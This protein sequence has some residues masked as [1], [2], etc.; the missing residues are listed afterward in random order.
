M[1]LSSKHGHGFLRFVSS[2]FIFFPSFTLHP[3]IRCPLV[4]RLLLRS[5]ELTVLSVIIITVSHGPGFAQLG[6][7]AQMGL[8]LSGIYSL[9]LLSITAMFH[10]HL[11]SPKSSLGLNPTTG[12]ELLLWKRNLLT[13]TL[14]HHCRADLSFLILG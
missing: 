8:L 6:H 14:H 4:L 3:N 9:S 10:S 2:V 1:A 12:H 5:A 11:N 13:S 7:V